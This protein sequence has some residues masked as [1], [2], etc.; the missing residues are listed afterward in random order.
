MASKSGHEKW[1]KYG[2]GNPR[3]GVLKKIHSTDFSVFF[4]NIFFSVECWTS[5]GAF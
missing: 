4:K 5:V 1:S 3:K 2:H